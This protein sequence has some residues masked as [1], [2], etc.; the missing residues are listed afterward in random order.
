MCRQSKENMITAGKHEIVFL[1][2]MM[3]VRVHKITVLLNE[4]IFLFHEMTV[5]FNEVMEQQF[6]FANPN[7]KVHVP[8]VKVN[9]LT[10]GEYE[11]ILSH[12]D[13]VG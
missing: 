9:V 6:F 13:P 4:V 11:L 1:F 7:G 12:A 8:L 5:I 10:A 2:H 3:T